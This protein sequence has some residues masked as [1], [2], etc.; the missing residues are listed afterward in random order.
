[1]LI[2]NLMERKVGQLPQLL[3]SLEDV[4]NARSIILPGVE[5]VVLRPP[6]V[7]IPDEVTVGSDRVPGRDEVPWVPDHADHHQ[8]LLVNVQFEK[9]AD[10]EDVQRVLGSDVAEP[11]DSMDHR[12]LEFFEMESDQRRA[13]HVVEQGRA[14]P[15]VPTHDKLRITRAGDRPDGL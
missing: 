7:V 1:M 11:V 8:L 6:T 5:P 3:Q 12:T 9:R 4:H 15:R 2:P 13:Q 10:V 14:T